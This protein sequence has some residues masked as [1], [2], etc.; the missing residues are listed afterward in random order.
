AGTTRDAIEDTMIL[1]GIKF[2]F[3]DTAGIR[4]TTDTVESI[5][6]EK[7]KRALEKAR[8][9]LFLYDTPTE[10]QFLEQEFSGIISSQSV[11][12]IKNKADLSAHKVN[13]TDLLISA[14]DNL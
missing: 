4:D 1:K 3:I 10:R 9:V 13:E 8:I 2:R 7:S 14:K 11:V 6:I 5:G 12:W